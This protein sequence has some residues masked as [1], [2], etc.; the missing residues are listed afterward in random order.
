MG[1]TAA[2]EV[3]V[4]RLQVIGDSNLV[5]LQTNGEWK[6]R[7]E[8][9]KPYHRMLEDLIPQFEKV[10]FTYVPRLKNQFADALATLAS[11]VELP[12]GVKMRPILIEQRDL[13]VSITSM[14]LKM[15]CTMDSLGI[16][17]SGI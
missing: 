2:L 13:R 1:L 4:E 16:T 11:M 6:V 15:K 9:L 7:E 17:I 12:V 14:Q 5:V 8:K 10:T 3:G